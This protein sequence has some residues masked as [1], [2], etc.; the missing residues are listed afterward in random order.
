MGLLLLSFRPWLAGE[1]RF[2]SAE[3]GSGLRGD[4]VCGDL[5]P[6]VGAH[7]NGFGDMTARLVVQHDWRTVGVREVLIAPLHED[8]DRTEQVSAGG[9]QPVLVTVGIAR[10][11]HLFQQPLIDKGA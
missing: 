2:F 5:L 3:A 10:V 9:G 11:G 6:A 8:H 7:K 4:V 1:R